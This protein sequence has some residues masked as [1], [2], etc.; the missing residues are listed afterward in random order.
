MF[1]GETIDPAGEVWECAQCR[2]ERNISAL[3]RWA[4]EN[5]VESRNRVKYAVLRW[6]NAEVL[7]DAVPNVT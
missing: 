1:G 2:V 6:D 7:L 4:Y 5:E 3:T